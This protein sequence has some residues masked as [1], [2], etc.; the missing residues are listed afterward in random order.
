MHQGRWVSKNT[1]FPM[2]GVSP[3]TSARARHTGL[4]MPGYSR[5]MKAAGIAMLA[6][7]PSQMAGLNHHGGFSGLL[8]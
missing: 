2:D 1:C 7:I 3:N 5:A 6:A 4:P 8:I